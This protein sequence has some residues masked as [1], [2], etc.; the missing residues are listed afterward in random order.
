MHHVVMEAGGGV[1]PHLQPTRTSPQTTGSPH[2]HWH[3]RLGQ[4]PTPSPR[5]V[6]YT[7]SHHQVRGRGNAKGVHRLHPY[8]VRRT[9]LQGQG[10]CGGRGSP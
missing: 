4:G 5:H 8:K 3:S 10:A 2:A 1:V 6:V 9:R 7:G